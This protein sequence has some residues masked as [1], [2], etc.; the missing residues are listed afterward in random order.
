MVDLIAMILVC[1]GTVGGW[2]SQLIR[3]KLFGTPLMLLS[4]VVYAA[5]STGSERNG[6]RLFRWPAPS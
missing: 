3:A 4:A 6:V 1:G 5:L 2:D